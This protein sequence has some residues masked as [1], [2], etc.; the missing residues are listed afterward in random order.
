MIS[1]TK[2]ALERLYKTAQDACSNGRNLDHVKLEAAYLDYET[3]R[4]ALTDKEPT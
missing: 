1:D 3:I 4:E 2:E